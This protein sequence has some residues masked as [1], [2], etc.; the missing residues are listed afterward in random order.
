M[1]ARHKLSVQPLTFNS[2][3]ENTY[4]VY[5]DTRTCAIVDPGCYT[6]QEQAALDACIAQHNLQ[7]THLINTHAHIDH[8]LG[9]QHVKATYGVPLALHALEAPILQAATQFAPCYGFPD[10]L[11]AE[12]DVLLAT[13]DI[14]QVGQSTLTVLHVP[15][16]SPGHIALYSAQNRFCLSG[17][18]LFRNSIGRTDLPGGDQASLL[19]SIHQQLLPLGDEV[20]VYPGHG[21]STTIGAE[22]SSNPFCRR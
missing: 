13:G 9:N 10:Y 2:L 17:D 18:V 7:V 1:T 4:I 21:P 14:I 5:D 20:V 11:P 19:Q 12:A 22:K 16:H 3:Q 6:P 8:V 15:G